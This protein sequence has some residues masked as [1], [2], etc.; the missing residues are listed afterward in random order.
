M[1][2]RTCSGKQG[3][4]NS[5]YYHTAN[6][7]S[8]SD[9]ISLFQLR[10]LYSSLKLYYIWI[11]VKILYLKRW[12]FKANLVSEIYVSVNSGVPERHAFLA[13]SAFQKTV[14]LHFS[15]TLLY[16]SLHK[17]FSDRGPKKDTQTSF[18]IT[19]VSNESPRQCNSSISS[20]S[21]LPK[22]SFLNIK[23]WIW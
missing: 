17:L 1:Q 20:F 8:V 12:W 2:W 16:R 6:S 7:I 23:L 4:A 13:L 10:L 15:K 22:G 5:S 19:S 9:K 3:V 14:V 21:Q 11:W 18:W